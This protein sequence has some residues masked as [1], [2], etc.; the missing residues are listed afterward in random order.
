MLNCNRWTVFI[1]T[2]LLRMTIMPVAH[3]QTMAEL[4]ARDRIVISVLGQG[5]R[6][7]RLNQARAQLAEMETALQTFLAQTTPV[8]REE[9]RK[10]LMEAIGQPNGQEL[11]RALIS[12]RVD[13]EKRSR[14]LVAANVALEQPPSDGSSSGLERNFSAAREALLSSLSLADNDETAVQLAAGLVRQ[15]QQGYL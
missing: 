7:H 5:V 15:T 1:L 2:A 3:A 11:L 8:E 12:D 14:W 4:N 9:S 6:A 13:P 10:Q